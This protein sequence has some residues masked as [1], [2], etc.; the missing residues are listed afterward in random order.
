MQILSIIFLVMVFGC[1]SPNA[2]RFYIPDILKTKPVRLAAPPFKAVDDIW[3]LNVQKKKKIKIGEYTHKWEANLY[4]WTDCA[5]ELFS[6]ILKERGAVIKDSSSHLVKMAVTDV[7]VDWG[8]SEI[9]CTVKLHVETGNSYK[10]T[11]VKK[12]FSRDL[13]D[14]CNGA[15][16]S[17]VSS[18]FEDKNILAYVAK[19]VPLC[20]IGPKDS[21]CDGVPDNIDKC[22]DTPPCVKVDDLGCPLDSDKDGVPDYLDRCP[23]TPLGAN[24]NKYGCWILKNIH[25]DFDK[26]NI[27]PK[28]FPYLDRIADIMKKNPSLDMELDGHTDI[29]G[30]ERYNKKLSI[31]RAL[32]VRDYLV[33]KG[34][35]KRRF[36]VKGFA[37]W[38]PIA[39]SNTEAG[40][41]LNRRVEF[42]PIIKR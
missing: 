16:R 32:S 21:D 1:A 37:Y 27:K 24:V 12:Y 2:K 40:R 34:I 8:F 18:L 7:D 10:K 9:D 5:V 22:P 19:K 33:S 38:R 39:P 25:F 31:Q 4:K 23:H 6:E 13:Y 35:S 15:L 11:V 36:I 17:A 26:Y 3:V 42:I 41:A 14:S 30:T 20:C 29:I 28:Y